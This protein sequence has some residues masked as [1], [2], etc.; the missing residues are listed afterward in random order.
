MF[1]IVVDQ[2]PL[3]YT[4]DYTVV[5]NAQEIALCRAAYANL[6]SG[7]LL[8]LFFMLYHAVVVPC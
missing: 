1:W 8:V 2:A 5:A 7:R 6:D 4:V 3:N